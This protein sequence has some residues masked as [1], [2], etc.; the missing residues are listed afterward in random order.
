[1]ASGGAGALAGNVTTQLINTGTVDAEEAR[2]ATDAGILGGAIG[3]GL[4]KLISK[5]SS[6]VMPKVASKIDDFA[7][8]VKAARNG[9]STE[10]LQPKKPLLEYNLQFFAESGEGCPFENAAKKVP[11]PNGKKGGTL[12]QNKIKSIKA[13]REAGKVRYEV[14]YDTPGGIKNY[15][16]ADAVE[17]VDG[18]ITKIHQ[19]GKI[20]KNGTP[21]IR[22][23]KAIAD[24]MGAPDY[25]GSPIYFWPYN[26]ESGP[27][28]YDF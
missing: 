19:V 11:N 25:N 21:V 20:N 15:R 13:S 16:Y 3:F 6:K 23:S 18:K 28:I 27:I 17:M 10:A 8:K 22:E 1:M 26:V 7:T 2:K 12:H 24:I 5:V 4:G 9:G 14:K